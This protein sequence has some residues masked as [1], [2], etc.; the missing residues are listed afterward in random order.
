MQVVD[1]LVIDGPERLPFIT[2]KVKHLHLMQCFDGLNQ[3]SLGQL[4]D[5]VTQQRESL[6]ANGA[7]DSTAGASISEKSQEECEAWDF[8]CL[9][10]CGKYNRYLLGNDASLVTGAEMNCD[11]ECVQEAGEVLQLGFVHALDVSAV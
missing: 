7:F 1:S 9:P 3:L 11:L 2:P 5:L 10:I 4:A 6:F 8:D